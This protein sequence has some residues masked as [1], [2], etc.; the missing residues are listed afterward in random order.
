MPSTSGSETQLE[1]SR[2]TVEKSQVA[3]EIARGTF[4]DCAEKQAE[5]N[6]KLSIPLCQPGEQVLVHR[7]DTVA[8]GPN[9]KLISPWRGP[10]TVRSQ[11]SPVVFRAARDGELAETSVHLGRI[12]AY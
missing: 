3:Y 4:Q 11:L 6:E 5:S 8:D 10:F 7:P 12:K 9:P 1:Y 2:R